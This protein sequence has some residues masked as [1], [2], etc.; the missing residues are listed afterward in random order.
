LRTEK[1]IRIAIKKF[2][3]GI[4]IIDGELSNEFDHDTKMDLYQKKCDKQQILL[5]LYWV[6]GIADKL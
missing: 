1:E 3:D 2:Q 6:I 4:E 5:T